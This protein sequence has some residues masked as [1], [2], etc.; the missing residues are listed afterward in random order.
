MVDAAATTMHR[1]DCCDLDK[2]TVHADEQ[3]ALQSRHCTF[4]PECWFYTHNVQSTVLAAHR[5]LK[6]RLQSGSVIVQYPGA[7]YTE[8]CSPPNILWSYLIAGVVC[9]K[10]HVIQ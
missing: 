3:H 6:A 5:T 9:R 10:Q 4:R 1:L 8:H 2:H 7:Y